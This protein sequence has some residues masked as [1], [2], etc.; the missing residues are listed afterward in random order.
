MRQERGEV[1]VLVLRE[2]EDRLAPPQP[3]VG[4][5]EGGLLRLLPAGDAVLLR[6]H[7][8]GG[9]PEDGEDEEQQDHH[10]QRDAALARVGSAISGVGHGQYPASRLRSSDVDES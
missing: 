5:V 3:G 9:D 8:R 6:H 2:T 4:G 7:H 1:G 10:D